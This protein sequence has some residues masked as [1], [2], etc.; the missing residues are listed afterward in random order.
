VEGAR[1]IIDAGRYMTLATA[2]ADGV[3]WAS[4]VWY[5]PE[6]HSRLLWISDPQMRHSRNLAVRPQLSIVIFDTAVPP[7]HGQA[8]YMAAEAGIVPE[9]E[10]DAARRVF[11][12]RSVAQGMEAWSDEDVRGRLRLYRAV[13]SEHWMLGEGRDERVPVTP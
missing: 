5:A 12:E 1:S 7:G 2:G 4:P 3:P 9:D 8:V 10:Y 11:S 13:V 6:G